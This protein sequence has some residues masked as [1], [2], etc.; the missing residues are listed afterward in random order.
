MAYDDGGEPFTMVSRK[1]RPKRILEEED[2][3]VTLGNNGGVNVSNL[4]EGKQFFR[5]KV[6]ADFRYENLN[7]G[8]N[9]NNAVHVL[10]DEMLK[11]DDSFTIISLDGTKTIKNMGEFPRQNSEF[12]QFFDFTDFAKNYK[13]KGLSY[14]ACFFHISVDFHEIHPRTGFP[15]DVSHWAQQDSVDGG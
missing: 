9:A 11:V 3:G 4:F 13:G 14:R 8:I 15:D 1:G 5:S 7:N 6:R 12:K 10:F 2:S